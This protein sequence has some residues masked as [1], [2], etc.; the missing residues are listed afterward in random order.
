V[1]FRAPP[2]PPL[3]TAPPLRPRTP[4]FE[5]IIVDVLPEELLLKEEGLPFVPLAPA[6]PVTVAPTR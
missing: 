2:T 5:E 1:V 6:V 4:L 3:S